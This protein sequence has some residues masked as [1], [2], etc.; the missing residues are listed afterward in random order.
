[1]GEG[2]ARRWPQSMVTPLHQHSPRIPW[3]NLCPTWP[4]ACDPRIPAPYPPGSKSITNRALILAALAAGK[5]SLSNVLFAD[6]TRVMLTAC[7]ALGFKLEIDERARQSPSPETGAIPVAAAKLSAKLR[8]L[9]RFLTAL[10]AL[11]AAIHPR[12]RR[13]MR[14]RPIGDLSEISSSSGVRTTI[15][16]A[17]DSPQSSS[18]PTS[19]RGISEPAPPNPASSSPRYSWPP[20]AR[21]EIRVD[22]IEPQPAGPNVAMI[23]A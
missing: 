13:R 15:S 2:S 14:Q 5:S 8:N 19:S 1:M 10:C 12:R 21:H 17:P 6:D 20:L 9:I 16:S 4:R 22:L 23:C 7:S 18:M 11:A 3:M